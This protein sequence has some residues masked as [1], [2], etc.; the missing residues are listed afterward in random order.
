MVKRRGH[1]LVLTATIAI[2]SVL[3]FTGTYN[4][5]GGIKLEEYTYSQV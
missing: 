4:Y 5:A 3:A 2:A 1:I